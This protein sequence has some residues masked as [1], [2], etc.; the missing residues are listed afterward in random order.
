MKVKYT[1]ESFYHGRGLTKGKIYECTAIEDEFLRIIDD[2]EEDYL[3]P[4]FMEWEIVEDPNG[5]LKKV[6]DNKTKTF[7]DYIKGTL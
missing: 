5:K 4:P 7:N 3:Y 6:L 2:E 1:G